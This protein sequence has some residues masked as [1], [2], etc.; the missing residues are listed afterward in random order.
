MKQIFFR[1]RC[2]YFKVMRYNLNVLAVMAALHNSSF[3]IIDWTVEKSLK[4]NSPRGC[5]VK[6]RD[7]ATTPPSITTEQN[8]PLPDPSATSRSKMTE[9]GLPRANAA[10]HLATLNPCSSSLALTTFSITEGLCGVAVIGLFSKRTKNLGQSHLAF[11]SFRC[12][13]DRRSHMDVWCSELADG[14]E[15]HHPSVLLLYEEP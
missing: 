15:P 9:S 5:H 11:L 8:T 14:L 6:L 4:P 10:S 7:F 12:S 2:V 1:R 3:S 13:I